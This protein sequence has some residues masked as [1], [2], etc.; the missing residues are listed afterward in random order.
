MSQPWTRMSHNL[1]NSYAKVPLVLRLIL[2][3]GERG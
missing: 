2:P 1:K 3:N